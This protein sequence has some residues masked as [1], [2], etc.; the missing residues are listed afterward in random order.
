MPRLS[1]LA[2][3]A[4]GVVSD[5]QPCTAYAVMRVFQVSTSTYFSGSAGA[6]YPLLKRLEATG[7]VRAKRTKAGSRPRRHYTLTAA[8]KSALT[9]WLCAPIPAADVD[10]TVDLLRTRVF[11]FDALGKRE[12]MKFVA[13]ARG[14]LE[15]RIEKNRAQMSALSGTADR[16]ERLATKSAVMADQSRLKWLTMLEKEF[17]E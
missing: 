15:A 10:F 7:L 4:L 12:R 3:I 8:G 13:N 6:I 11:F 16:F 17:S 9:K 2:Y 5:E 1:H 14:L